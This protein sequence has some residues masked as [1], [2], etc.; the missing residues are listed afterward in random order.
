MLQRI[1]MSRGTQALLLAPNHELVMQIHEV[2][3]SLGDL[4]PGLQVR[5][6]VSDDIIRIKKKSVH[7]PRCMYC[8]VMKSN[9]NVE[10]YQIHIG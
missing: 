4:M 6:A 10:K 2:I 7:H 8:K 1:M 5:T 9:C 3:S